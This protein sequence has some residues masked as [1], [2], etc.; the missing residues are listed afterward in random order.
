MG[1]LLARFSATVGRA[2]A[3]ELSTKSKAAIQ[4]NASIRHAS[5]VA[6]K[7]NPLQRANSYLAPLDTQQI[8]K[9][10]TNPQGIIRPH[11]IQIIIPRSPL[12]QARDLM[13]ELGITPNP[14]TSALEKAI[15]DLITSPRQPNDPNKL[16]VT[17]VDSG[18]GGLI[19][20]HQALQAIA[21][22]LK[23]LAKHYDI[24]VIVKHIGDTL[25]APYGIKL[26]IEVLTLATRL[27]ILAG[28]Q[29]TDKIL[30]GCNTA[31]I[32]LDDGKALLISTSTDT[33]T[34]IPIIQK[35]AEALYANSRA[36]L[37]PKTKVLERHVL[38]FGT[39]SAINS[40]AFDRALNEIHAKQTD[41]SKLKIHK[42]APP[43]WVT[44]IET[45]AE[46]HLQENAVK[47]VLDEFCKSTT[48]PPDE[49]KN[50]TSIGLFCT[51]FPFFEKQ[52]MEML[53]AKSSHFEK[54]NPV[55][56]GPLFGQ[57][58]LK[59]ILEKIESGEI[60]KRDT[61]LT[62]KE[63]LELALDDITTYITGEDLV[64][65]QYAIE[66]LNF[67]NVTAKFLS[68]SKNHSEA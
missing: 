47:E 30:I 60:K 44:L 26:P 62:E 57:D 34:A 11:E 35:S 24:S 13:V 18:L 4:Q 42:I 49:L 43:T 23:E 39:I 27:V 50:I 46:K 31:S 2:R 58:I 10:R 54:I 25:F 40:G 12:Q 59:N 63:V 17:A 28:H 22:E 37:N 67:H 9:L 6:S 66:T 56:Q 3:F 7:N 45:G 33:V 51:H 53:S 5:S 38:V 32:Q 52:I 16:R 21:P 15:V 55:K 36:V 64:P 19:F 8:H 65:T 14:F 61:P 68:S 29:G 48:T 20:I 41:G 1:S